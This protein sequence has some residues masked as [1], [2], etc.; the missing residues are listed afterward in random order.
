MTA[1]ARK[2]VAT[3][4]MPDFA[5][6]LAGAKLPERTLPVCLRGDLQAQHETADREL[7]ALLKAGSSKFNDGSGA[8]KA[9]L[10]AL[11]A[12]MKAATY[13]F[14]LQGLARPQYRAFIAGYPMRIQED[15]S[16][17]QEDRVFGFNIEDGAEPLV[18]R[19]LVDPV[20]DAE[21]WSRLMAALTERQFDDLAGAAWYLNRGDV[22]VPFSRAASRLTETSEPE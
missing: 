21:A 20:L 11:E 2:A 7:E 10:L 16:L 13:E 22:D 3:A 18:R 19:C 1:R 6:L 15:G 12:E 4:K 17:H 5:A 14:R 8:L 9:K